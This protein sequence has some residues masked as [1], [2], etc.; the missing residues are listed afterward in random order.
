[1]KNANLETMQQLK[2]QGMA[3]A[4]ETIIGL[5]INQQPDKHEMIA[6]LMDAEAR[7][8]QS[9]RMELFLRLAKLRYRATLHDIDCSEK[10]NLTKEQILQLADGSY[11]DRSENVLITGATG[12]GK[13]Y[14]ACALGHQACLLGKRTLYYNMNRFCEQI[15]LAQTDGTLIKWLNRLKKAK[16]IIFDDFGL[17]PLTHQVKLLILQILEDRYNESSVLISSQLP[18]NKWYDYFAEP[19]LADAI[20]D[21]IL[22]K[23]HRIELQGKSLREKLKSEAAVS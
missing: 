5:P 8:R 21:R 15:A 3:T 12:C 13:S 6:T 10:R 19:T 17:Q 20:L 1:M 11:I 18:V 22:P 2:L 4:Y 23:A 7:Y 16:L 9:R 14:L